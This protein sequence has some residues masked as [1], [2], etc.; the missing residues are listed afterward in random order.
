M[1]LGLEWL[2]GIWEKQKQTNKQTNKTT[3]QNNKTTKQNK[4]TQTKSGSFKLFPTLTWWIRY[5]NLPSPTSCANCSGSALIIFF[6]GGGGRKKGAKH[7]SWQ[8]DLSLKKVISFDHFVLDSSPQCK[9]AIICKSSFIIHHIGTILW[10]KIQHVSQL[11]QEQYCLTR[12]THTNEVDVYDLTCIVYK[13]SCDET[14]KSI[15]YLL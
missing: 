2:H 15:R 9:G 8:Q 12:Y 1:V 3:K 14:N 11:N 6:G 10:N 5:D 13:V 7:F 4:T